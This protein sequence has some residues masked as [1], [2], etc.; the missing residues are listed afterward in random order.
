MA[1][2]EKKNSGVGLRPTGQTKI[3][4]GGPARSSVPALMWALSAPRP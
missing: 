3:L 1:E 4:T 2:E